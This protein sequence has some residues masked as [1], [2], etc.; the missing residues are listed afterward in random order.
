MALHEHS[1]KLIHTVFKSLTQN[2]VKISQV[3][4]NLKAS[5]QYSQKDVNYEN[6]VRASFARDIKTG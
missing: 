1:K 5:H 2:L 6:G 3:N 4:P